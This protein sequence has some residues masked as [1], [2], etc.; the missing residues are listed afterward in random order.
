MDFGSVA[1]DK[2]SSK[3]AHPCWAALRALASHLRTPDASARA[4]YSAES[5]ARGVAVGQ[6]RRQCADQSRPQNPGDME[7][8]C[9]ARRSDMRASI[10]DLD[11]GAARAIATAGGRRRVMTVAQAN[12]AMMLTG[13][14]NRAKMVRCGF[15]A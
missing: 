12:N 13:R 3:C 10:V 15:C 1:V 6:A 11:V 9:T 4:D 2:R 14:K 8:G 7:V 5:C